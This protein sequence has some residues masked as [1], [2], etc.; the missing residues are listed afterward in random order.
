MRARSGAVRFALLVL[1]GAAQAQAQ[2]QAQSPPPAGEV[3]DLRTAV[4]AALATHPELRAA[5]AAVRG[6]SARIDAAGLRPPLTET[7]ELVRQ[8]L[9]LLRGV[10]VPESQRAVELLTRGY[11]LGRFSYLEIADAQRQSI[12]AARSLSELTLRF[13]QT[14]LELGRLL[15]RP[16]PS[17]GQNP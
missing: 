5:D 10:I 8:E 11:E 2:A 7:L 9:E 3:L 1:A 6:G 4:E 14:I 17:E 15:G 12:E 13:H 16:Q